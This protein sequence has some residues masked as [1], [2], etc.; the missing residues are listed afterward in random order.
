VH[1]H[2]DGGVEQRLVGDDLV[3]LDAAGGRDD[4]LGLAIVDP[5]RELIGREAAED[6]RVDAPSRAQASMAIAASGTMGM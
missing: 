3:D 1:R 2:D 5:G 6:H 4:E